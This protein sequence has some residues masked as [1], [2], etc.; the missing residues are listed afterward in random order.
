MLP[1]FQP[2]MDLCRPFHQ[3]LEF[4]NGRLIQGSYSYIKKLT[5]LIAHQM[6]FKKGGLVLK[7][8]LMSH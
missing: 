1:N 4:K 3:D 7:T 8:Y 5:I 6:S 2:P